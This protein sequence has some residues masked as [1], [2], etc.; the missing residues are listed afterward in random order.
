MSEL[1]ILGGSDIESQGINLKRKNFL[2]YDG[3]FDFLFSESAVNY[4]T[5]FDVKNYFLE[6]IRKG[7]L[8]ALAWGFPRGGLP[9]GRSLQPVLENIAFY[10]NCIKK[11]KTGGLTPSGYDEINSL[12]GV[13][14]GITTKFMYFSG[15]MVGQSPAL[16]FD[17]RVR[18]FLLSINPPEFSTVVDALSKYSLY[19]G[20]ECYM[21]F[22]KLSDQFARSVIVNSE[23]VEYCMF[24]YS[25]GRMAPSH[26]MRTNE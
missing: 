13:K 3:V 25:P 16:I 9:G 1:K 22:C 23:F 26:F 12:L 8:S 19:P 20:A 15:V 6:D 14:N 17:S 10:E 18:N 21:E 24:K 11:L 5:R 2:R 7:L 4:V